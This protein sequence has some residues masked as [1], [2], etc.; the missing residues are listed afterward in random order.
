MVFLINNIP[1][2]VRCLRLRFLLFYSKKIEFVL[3]KFN[4]Q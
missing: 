2:I 4:F 1:H 3:R